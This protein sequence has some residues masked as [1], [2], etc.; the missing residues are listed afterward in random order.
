MTAVLE[1]IRV[2]QW[3]KNGFVLAPLFFGANLFHHTAVMHAMTALLAFCLASSGVYVFNDWRDMAADRMHAVK[4]NRPL[5][6]GRVSVPAALVIMALLFAGT[7]AVIWIGRLPQPFAEII[8]LYLVINLGYSLGLKQ[9]TVIELLMISSGFVLRLLAGGVALSVALSPW[10]VIATAT[11]ALLLATGKRRGDIVRG[12]DAGQA[13]K[14]LAGYSL[15]YL[16]NVL[17]ALVGATLVVYLLFCVSD[18]AVGRYGSN[19]L[20]TAIPVAAGLMRYL[21]LLVVYGDGD[22]PSDLVMRDKGLVAAV[23][24]FIAIFGSLI[25]LR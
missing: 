20:L 5:A 3:V 15:A 1:L 17:A 13:R 18:Y 6:S 22:S 12:N 24:I 9:V 11:I 2:R 7:A 19:V 16:D 4:K 10:I 23:L 21:Q 8:L 14:S 25:Y